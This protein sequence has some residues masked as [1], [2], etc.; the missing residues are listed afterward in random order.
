MKLKE[1]QSVQGKKLSENSKFLNAISHTVKGMKGECP[2][3]QNLDPKELEFFNQ[4]YKKGEAVNFIMPAEEN[5]SKVISLQK[6][7]E[8]ACKS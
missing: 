1:V 8:L 3:V 5:Y 4:I 7:L 6:L 2:I